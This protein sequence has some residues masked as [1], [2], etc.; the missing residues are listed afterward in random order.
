M[1]LSYRFITQEYFK[2]IVFNDISTFFRPP[3]SSLLHK[4]VLYFWIFVFPNE[5]LLYFNSFIDDIR[6]L[7]INARWTILDIVNALKTVI[8]P[9]NFKFR[10][11]HSLRTIS[12]LVIC[13]R[14][15]IQFILKK[16]KIKNNFMAPFHGW[17]SNT[18]KLEPL[19]GGSLLLNTEFPDILVLILLTSE[20]WK[21]ESTLE[22]PS[23]FEHR[24][25]GLGIQHLNH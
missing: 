11:R 14:K 15:S 25:P 22:P 18:S 16:K 3:L 2:L 9:F 5:L 19:R 13:F 6:I 21:A 24:T 4:V 20:G 7:V 12:M 23:D 8:F 17:G 10:I 1:V